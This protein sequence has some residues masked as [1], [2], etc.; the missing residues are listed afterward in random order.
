LT[1]PVTRKEVDYN[2]LQDGTIT[3]R[4]EVW[5]FAYQVNNA[6]CNSM[7]APDNGT[8]TACFTQL[9]PR[10]EAL[11]GTIYKRTSPTGQMNEKQYSFNRP[12]WDNTRAPNPYVSMEVITV[13]GQTSMAAA[14]THVLDA[15]GNELQTNSYDYVPYSSI[16]H[17]ATGEVTGTPSG[18]LLRTIANTYNPSVPVWTCPQ[19]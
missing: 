1:N 6:F 12:A 11:T 7:T 8:D 2:D 5:T 15:N 18:A 4:S 13:A 9:E 17:G 3:P 14:T 19:I 10:S 16:Q